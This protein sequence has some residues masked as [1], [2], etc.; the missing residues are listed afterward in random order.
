MYTEKEKEKEMKNKDQEQITEAYL[1]IF[2]K[3]N[4]NIGDWKKQISNIIREINTKLGDLTRSDDSVLKEKAT[5]LYTILQHWA[6]L[7]IYDSQGAP[8][9]RKFYSSQGS[10]ETRKFVADQFAIGPRPVSKQEADMFEYQQ[11]R[12]DSGNK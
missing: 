9:T 7:N 2:L 11:N 4:E 1:K 10:P 6:N 3:E 5:T 8:E 12:M